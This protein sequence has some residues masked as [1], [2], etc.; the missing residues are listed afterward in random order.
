MPDYKV[1]FRT[2]E[3]VDGDYGLTW[4]PPCPVAITAIQISRNVETSE[5]FLQIKIRNISDIIVNSITGTATIVFPDDSTESIDFEELDFDVA[6]GESKAINARSLSRADATSATAV[7]KTAV[8]GQNTWKSGSPVIKIPR[9]EKLN[10]STKAAKERLRRLTEAHISQS[11]VEGKVID[12]DEWWICACG[13]INVSGSECCECRSSKEVLLGTESEDDLIASSDKW[14]ES[15]YNQAKELGGDGANAASLKEAIDLLGSID[16]WKDSANLK[17]EYEKRLDSLNATTASKRRKLAIIM[18][19]S[20]VI[21]VAAILL[22]VNVLIPNSKYDKAMGLV[23]SGKYDDAIAAFEELHGYKDSIDQI[24]RVQELKIE[25]QNSELYEEAI[26]RING[27][28]YEAGI[29]ILESLGDYE[30]A[31]DQLT[32]AKKA[33]MSTAKVGDTIS[34]GEYG[35]ESV[36]WI[37]LSTNGKKMLLV[38][39]SI[40][41]QKPFNK[42]KSLDTTWENCS[43]RSW[44]NEDFF[45]TCFSA[46]EQAFIAT[47]TLPGSTNPDA[48]QWSGYKSSPYGMT[49]DATTED[50]VFILSLEEAN[51]YFT[52]EN[53]AKLIATC[54]RTAIMDGVYHNNKSNRGMYYLRTPGDGNKSGG[55]NRVSM[56]SYD[57]DIDSYAQATNE[58]GFNMPGYSGSEVGVRPA[59]WVNLE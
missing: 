44:L 43:L 48:K 39:D 36:D 1:V 2:D 32:S 15:V 53:K 27:G 38:S 7:M 57:G 11:A 21:V 31:I 59:I 42:T 34:F 56:V 9:G 26:Q 12:N 41:E 28:D 50:K 3:T 18:A 19:A 52:G 24:I 30:D 20:A 23:E 37:V 55:C 8:S 16:V 33:Y 51:E 14:S 54:T 40:I 22:A 5:A 17:T 49:W 29:I 45:D 35:G 47:S 13:Q 6:P 10:L 4:E 25:E 46:D 58:N